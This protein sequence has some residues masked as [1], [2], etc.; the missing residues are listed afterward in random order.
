MSILYITYDGILEPLGQ[1]QVLAYLEK[2][3]NDKTIYIISFEKKKD[4]K[5]E[6]LLQRIKTRLSLV[7]IHWCP[8]KYH[9]RFSFFATLFDVLQGLVFS[10][11]IINRKDIKII[12]ARSYVPSIIAL[13]MKRVFSVKFIFD[14]R[15]F[16]ADER[17]DG[18]IWKKDSLLFT[19]A[20][21]FEKSFFLQA[22]HVVSL[23]HSGVQA[24]QQFEYLKSKISSNQFN[25]SVIPT[26]VDLI[27]FKPSAEL[28][29]VFTLGYVG[30][31]GF[32]YDFDITVQAFSEF[33]KLLP[34]GKILIVNKDEHDFIQRKLV[35]SGLPINQIDIISAGFEEI[36]SL[37]NQMDAGIFFIKPL[38][39]KLAS[40]PTKL[41]EFLGCGI[42]CL[43]NDGIGDVTAILE[44][45][46]AGIIVSN[47]N[48]DHLSHAMQDL[49]N[50]A[51]QENIVNECVRT[52]EE[53]FS[54]KLGVREYLK[55]YNA[56]EKTS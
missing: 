31:A 48:P 39:S 43:S 56:L 25:Y 35:A 52:A 1:S 51:K 36:P 42:P 50:L 14:M 16:W 38:F 32:W 6:E 46:E 9:K 5:N 11:W 22:S 53:Y 55:I 24:I 12:H 44:K 8:L 40:A 2:L 49:I 34:D 21:K 41:G 3:A 33:F 10:S 27:R 29:H 15:G 30:S 26:C 47:D 20:K 37:M 17:I 23:T 4:L 45:N 13:A 54:L 18:G 19:V 28:R 7:D